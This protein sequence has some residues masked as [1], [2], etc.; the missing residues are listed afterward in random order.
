M[1]KCLALAWTGPEIV[2][3][4]I[5]REKYRPYIARGAGARR[6]LE[7][8]I[9]AQDPR[10]VVV[11]VDG[12]P[13]LA[14][15]SDV[16]G[17][18]AFIVFDSVTSLRGVVGASMLDQDPARDDYAMKRLSMADLH[19]AIAGPDAPF[20]VPS[21]VLKVS[22]NL[23]AKITLRELM[24]KVKRKA[25]A[26]V[27]DEFIA[28][29]C[30]RI[31]GRIH[32]TTWVARVRK[33]AL[34]AGMDT[35]ALAE[36]ERFIEDSSVSEGLWKGFYELVENKDS[37]E[38]IEKR[39]DVRRVDLE[40]LTEILGGEAVGSKAYVSSPAVRKRRGNA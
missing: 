34:A 30:E 37:V 25:G 28:K 40:Y 5:D 9:A 13:T 15:V 36:L 18:K 27:T 23:A 17:V 16:E 24:A 2:I 11:L 20:T 7:M 33:P 6:D 39:Y 29:T 14:R 26:V 3:I 22:E 4:D 1:S 32:K 35:Q 38:D 31:A 21:D 12:V 10:E 19:V 8:A